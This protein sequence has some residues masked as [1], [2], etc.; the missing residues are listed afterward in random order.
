LQL[1]PQFEKCSYVRYGRQGQSVAYVVFD[2]IRDANGALQNIRIASNAFKGAFDVRCVS[3]EAY[4][5]ECRA[6][7]TP[8][9]GFE[10]QVE[11]NVTI[12]LPNGASIEPALTSR[13]IDLAH[14]EFLQFAYESGDWKT[15]KWNG[16]GVTSW[17][18]RVE[19]Y[20]AEQAG[21]FLD[22]GRRGV[23]FSIDDKVRYRPLYGKTFNSLM[24]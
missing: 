8:F 2:D 1:I 16:D 18:A 12:L 4:N 22:A 3:Y 9:H 15:V 14:S 7:M 19:F 11:A 10:T 23:R 24:A 20:S 17:Y 21:R 13:I 6:S 5:N